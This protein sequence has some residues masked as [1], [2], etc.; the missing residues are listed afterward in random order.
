[1]DDARRRVEEFVARAAALSP[2]IRAHADAS[3]RARRLAPEV[4]DA[5]H[6]AGLFRALLPE[7]F[8]GAGLDLAQAVPLFEEVA[9]ADG[10]AGWNLAI[11]ATTLSFVLMLDDE[12]AIEEILKTPRALLAGSINPTALRIV[13]QDGGYRVRGRLQY[14]SGVHQSNWL[15]AGGLVFDGDEPR[16]AQPGLPVL[17]SAFFP[18]SEARVLDTWWVNGLAGTGSHDVEVADV[19]VPAA[20]SYDVL[21]V[22]PKRYEPLA[23]LPLPSRLGA[24]LI[25]VGVG[26]VRRAIDELCAL[27]REKTPFA[28]MRPLRER[29]GVQIDVARAAGL[30]DAA[31][32]HV[33]GVC[34]ETFARVRGGGTAGA[35]DL[36]RLRLACVTASEQLLHAVDL[37]RSA[38]GI[39]AIFSGSPLERCWRDAHAVSQHFTLSSSHLEKLG[40]I[41]LGFDP[42]PGPI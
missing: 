27:A 41:R 9:C 16:F 32:A 28:S 6:D 35:S 11:G 12:A 21:A 15:H 5:F 19:F 18:T 36:A 24:S 1:M 30:L 17:R 39:T 31:R 3:E 4:V 42:G 34:G 22:A 8:G 29:A 38:A 13:P 33:Q 40:R 10:S 7:R 37:V 26:I 23:T 14:A 2:L 20:R 25:G